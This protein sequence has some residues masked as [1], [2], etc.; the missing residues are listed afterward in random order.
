[1]EAKHSLAW[2]LTHSR[3]T[4]RYQRRHPHRVQHLAY[5]LT[6]DR[7]W[8]DPPIPALAIPYLGRSG[9]APV[10]AGDVQARGEWRCRSESETR[11]SR[12]R[13]CWRLL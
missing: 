7:T 13:G 9:R 6:Y 8:L 5:V 3:L 11:A 4:V 2:L 10:C 1:M 12:K